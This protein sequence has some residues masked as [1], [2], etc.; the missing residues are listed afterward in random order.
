MQSRPPRRERRR[1]GY[2]LN[3]RMRLMVWGCWRLTPPLGLARDVRRRRCRRCARAPRSLHKFDL[4]AGE[5]GGASGRRGHCHGRSD[6]I[7]RRR[8]VSGIMC[9][10]WAL[11]SQLNKFFAV[12][13]F[14]V[15]RTLPIDKF[16]F[17]FQGR[18]APLTCQLHNELHT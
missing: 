4:Q 7:G 5:G 2:V 13:F 8:P 14:P 17:F 11:P 1:S 15:T 12:A 18:G 6:V 16:F 3:C 9:Y 10:I